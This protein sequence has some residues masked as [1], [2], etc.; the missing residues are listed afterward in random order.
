VI[1][2]ST[3]SG[4]SITS[5]L[6]VVLPVAGS[7]TVAVV[8]A[9]A[10]ILNRQR[11]NE[12][13]LRSRQPIVQDVA[14]WN[15]VLVAQG[16]ALQ[17]TGDLLKRS[18]FYE[19]GLDEEQSRRDRHRPLS[20]Q[21][22]QVPD[23]NAL[24]RVREGLLGL[25]AVRRAQLSAIRSRNVK[26]RWPEAWLEPFFRRSTVRRLQKA[27]RFLVDISYL[28]PQQGVKDLTVQQDGPA[29]S[30]QQPPEATQSSPRP[31]LFRRRRPSLT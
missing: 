21:L 9:A 31:G 27:E 5:V 20:G 15:A 23:E 10:G 2:A 3:S 22:W 16:Q 11:A 8:G 14:A 17:V 25:D 13:Q 24:R 29:G 30:A 4:T 28:Q 7:I 12:A 18:R 26:S 6:T 19:R 1:L